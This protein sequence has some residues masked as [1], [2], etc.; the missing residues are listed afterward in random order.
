M[1][2]TP[3]SALRT[4][5]P[6]WPSTPTAR[7][8]VLDEATGPDIQASGDLAVILSTFREHWTPKA[9]GETAQQVGQWLVVWQRQA[10]GSWLIIREMWAIEAAGEAA[11]AG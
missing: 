6:S 5:T 11:G 3:L 4:R 10:D 1:P 8:G 2:T 7:Y 9:G